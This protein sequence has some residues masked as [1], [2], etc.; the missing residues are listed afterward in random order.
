MVQVGVCDHYGVDVGGVARQLRPVAAAQVR[1]ALE[2]AAFEEDPGMVALDEE[3]AAGDGSDA[4]EEAQQRGSRRGSAGP[5][6]VSN[7]TGPSFGEW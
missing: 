5:E 6:S 7:M 3:F 2:E 1:E 4:A